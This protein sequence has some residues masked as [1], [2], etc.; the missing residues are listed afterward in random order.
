MDISTTPIYSELLNH[1]AS[2][3]FTP[4]GDLKW[5]PID[6]TTRSW[7]E[8]E[9]DGELVYIEKDDSR[10]ILA[11]GSSIPDL[12]REYGE[13]HFFEDGHKNGTVVRFNSDIPQWEMEEAIKQM[14][15]LRYNIKS[16]N[17]VR[18]LMETSIEN[19]KYD[20]REKSYALDATKVLKNHGIL[21]LGDLLGSKAS[22]EE[23]VEKFGAGERGVA[24]IV[25]AVRECGIEYGEHFLDKQQMKIEQEYIELYR[26][27]AVD[28]IIDPA[29]L[30]RLKRLQN[31]LGLSDESVERITKD[32]CELHGNKEPSKPKR[33]LPE[34]DLAN[35]LSD[36]FTKNKFDIEKKE[37]EHRPDGLIPALNSMDGRIAMA[38]LDSLDIAEYGAFADLE[39]GRF[40]LTDN[41]IE[42]NEFAGCQE[43]DFMTLVSRAQDVVANWNRDETT[44]KENFYAELL[45]KC[46]T[47]EILVPVDVNYRIKVPQ[48][49]TW[50]YD[51]LG[52]NATNVIID[53]INNEFLSPSELVDNGTK[54]VTGDGDKFLYDLTFRHYFAVRE[55]TDY[56]T[57]NYKDI[58][59][60]LQYLI[61]TALNEAFGVK[62]EILFEDLKA[63]RP[64]IF[65]TELGH[66][67][68]VDDWQIDYFS[69]T[70]EE[71]I[72]GIDPEE[73]KEIG[74]DGANETATFIAQK[75]DFMEILDKN[76]LLKKF[77][78]EKWAVGKNID[79]PGIN[80][81]PAAWEMKYSPADADRIMNFINL[82]GA[83]ITKP[84]CEALLA[85]FRNENTPIVTDE[86]GNI[87]RKE[88]RSDKRTGNEGP[89]LVMYEPSGLIEDYKEI[90]E[91][92]GSSPVLSVLVNTLDDI[93]DT[94]VA[95]EEKRN[96]E[97]I[98][99]A[100]AQEKNP[101]GLTSSRMKNI[102]QW[103]VPFIVNGD[104]DGLT[105]EEILQAEK[106][107]K[108]TG[109]VSIGEIS[110]PYFASSP[111]F[112]MATV[113]V[114]MD[115]LLKEPEKA[116]TLLCLDARELTDFER[117][118]YNKELDKFY[119]L[120]ARG[121]DAGTDINLSVS[122]VFYERKDSVSQAKKD[123]REVAI[124]S[125]EKS[126]NGE[127][128]RTSYMTF[129]VRRNDRNEIVSFQPFSGGLPSERKA[130]IDVCRV[131]EPAIFN[132]SVAT[133]KECVMKLA[134]DGFSIRGGNNL[135]LTYQLL[136]IDG[137]HGERKSIEQN[138]L[139]HF[140]SG[141]KESC[142]GDTSIGNIFLQASK[143]LNSCTAAEKEIIS[144][145]FSKF[146]LDSK[147][148]LEA[149]LRK[150]VKEPGRK[151]ERGRGRND[152]RTW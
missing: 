71:F 87:Y 23:I 8:F 81:K 49:F 118:T 116:K 117:A 134:K 93:Q 20:F 61:G 148:K 37:S 122:K 94:L 53:T 80:Q 152:G 10:K 1:F 3:I 24:V 86:L 123:K 128:G 34:K 6:Y 16:K 30:Y 38:V 67:V 101:N 135:N 92:K 56:S 104:K 7:L 138:V 36:Y 119:D 29:E 27:V 115:V 132:H 69:D 45:D 11:L 22:P 75:K 133:D 113:C 114:D 50:K 126:S 13:A 139:S 33:L 142:S 97:D 54:N 15:G 136:D 111:E 106:F 143:R 74:S 105:D 147:Q 120:M 12:E 19:L 42:Y 52:R 60:H 2:S 35:E 107:M 96:E 145:A 83:H 64:V 84:M 108:D 85:S 77:V 121:E 57:I 31:E 127:M 32:W 68:K 125:C 28:G 82:E 102:P 65:Y 79:S 66:L 91:N 112:G 90:L 78:E 4:D 5:N 151:I 76:P 149:F 103:A 21:T 131:F 146:G 88:E 73:L 95:H 137:F 141:V 62:Q 41:D 100:R 47:D 99:Q 48:E 17:E 25:S 58:E 43:V 44:V 110:E 18:E 72:K 14:L 39:N 144:A 63:S 59:N 124:V 98:V 46:Y 129:E 140:L 9:K 130:V 51:E 89:D 40:W 26:D 70:P 109:I 55:G 150:Q